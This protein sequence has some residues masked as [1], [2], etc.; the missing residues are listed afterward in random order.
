M[1]CRS[2]AVG[3]AVGG[4]FPRGTEYWSSSGTAV[5]S[6]SPSRFPSFPDFPFLLHYCWCC[7]SSGRRLRA[8][9]RIERVC[10]GRWRS[11]W[12][13]ERGIFSYIDE[14]LP[15]FVD[16]RSVATPL[17]LKK[18]RCYRW[19]QQQKNAAAPSRPPSQW[20]RPT[21]C[22]KERTTQAYW[23]MHPTKQGVSVAG[24]L[25]CA[26]RRVLSLRP[27]YFILFLSYSTHIPACRYPVLFLDSFFHSTR[28]VST[29]ST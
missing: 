16:Q 5:P 27:P 20:D 18:E 24:D 11:Q 3:S 28:L 25:N 12:V 22:E 26:R 23:G 9:E 29:L 1:L 7:C 6:C 10:M 21:E 4:W 14:E 13:E 15:F 2:Q 19:W 8:T 17:E